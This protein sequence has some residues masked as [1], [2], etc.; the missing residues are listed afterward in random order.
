MQDILTVSNLFNGLILVVGWSIRN[1]LHYI[2]NSITEA[3]SSAHEAHKRIDDLL[4][5]G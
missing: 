5:K 2:R 3:K 4:V 1:E